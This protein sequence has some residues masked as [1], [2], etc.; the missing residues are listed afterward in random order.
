MTA[1]EVFMMRRLQGPAHWGKASL[2]FNIRVRKMEV[3]IAQSCP[4]L[5]DC[6]NYSPS[7]SSVHGIL[8]ARRLERVATAF[9][10]GSSQP[11]DQSQVSHITLKGIARF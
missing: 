2:G 5:C 8:Q 4:T 11:R 7:G 1:G 9:S 6:M 3:L 10:W